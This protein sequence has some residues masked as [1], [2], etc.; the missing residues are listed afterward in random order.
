MTQTITTCVVPN[1]DGSYG[2]SINGRAAVDTQCRTFSTT[3]LGT[4]QAAAHYLGCGKLPN[5]GAMAHR[6]KSIFGNK[7]LRPL[8]NPAV[9]SRL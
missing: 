7:L 1:E 8:F 2:V 5:D 9:M 3:D 6:V 4:A